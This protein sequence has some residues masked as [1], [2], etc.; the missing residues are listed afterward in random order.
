MITLFDFMDV[1]LVG[2]NNPIFGGC[3]FQL[4]RGF[5]VWLVEALE[6]SVHVSKL[7]LGPCILSPVNIS[8]RVDTKTVI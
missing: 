6:D 1:V 5:Q 2:Y 8:G 3:G 4:H 7:T